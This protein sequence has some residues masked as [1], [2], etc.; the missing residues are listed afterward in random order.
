MELEYAGVSLRWAHETDVGRV[1]ALNEDS[2]LA[3]P[4]VF[5]VADGMGGHDA[6]EVASALVVN[7]LETLMGNEP[8]EVD[9]V[10]TELR[11]VHTLLQQATVDGRQ[12]QMGTT[13]VGLFLV[14]SGG[15]LSWLIA[16]VGDSR[17]YCFSERSLQQMT[18]DHSYVQELVE[19]GQITGEE[20]RHHP[21]RNVITQALGLAAEIEPDFWLRPVVSGERFVLCSD[22]L[23][24]EVR[25]EEISG[26][27][28]SQDDPSDAVRSLCSLALKHGGRDNVTAIVVDVVATAADTSPTTET[29][30]REKAVIFD[31][32]EINGVPLALLG[33]EGVTVAAK[34][35][36]VIDVVPDIDGQGKGNPS[37][38]TSEV[39]LERSMIDGVP[40]GSGEPPIGSVESVAALGDPPI[41]GV[42][43]EVP[44]DVAVRQLD[45]ES[46]PRS[47]KGVDPGII[48]A[49]PA[50]RGEA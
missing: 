45:G 29:G 39:E 4:P 23:T 18:R 15:I 14:R 5:A 33:R 46:V 48:E 49:M 9:E 42:I 16:N 3:V 17:A 30:H 7:R 31:E 22:G 26:I 32:N 11:S 10:A 40:S 35:I 34:E 20:A 50:D 38:P 27:L 41:A 19:S 36:A 1:R 2:Y 43:S 8:P 24:G 13:L 25:D 12:V 37:A 47:D 28:A 6:G 21:E 44:D